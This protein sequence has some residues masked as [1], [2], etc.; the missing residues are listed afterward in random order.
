MA[1]HPRRAVAAELSYHIWEHLRGLA[2][3]R[4]AEFAAQ[5]RDGVSG[6]LWEGTF[7]ALIREAIPGIA[8]ADLRRAREH[9]NAS[10]MVVNVHG[11]QRGA[12]PQ[13]FI[14]GDW[15]QG[16]GGHVH[17]VGAS[18]PSQ[19]PPAPPPGQPG[20]PEQPADP[21]APAPRPDL[22]P[23][24][25]SLLQQVSDLQSDND[26]LRADNVRLRAENEHIRSLAREIAGKM[27]QQAND[28]RDGAGS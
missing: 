6:W 13:W 26:R 15:H 8:E 4:P 20:R 11:Q 9:L 27:A 17:V 5:T 14:R 24:L 18:R 1:P 16:P 25:R 7:A 21:A 12:Q 19:P 22:M 23:A 3:S 10:G 28:L 2:A